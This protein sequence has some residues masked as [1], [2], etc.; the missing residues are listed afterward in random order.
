MPESIKQSMKWK[1]ANSPV[2][3]KFQ[4]QQSV[5]K[6]ML[7]LFRN[8]EGPII[9]DF[10]EKVITVTSASHCQLLSPIHLIY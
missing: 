3:K 9:I 6:V 8:M 7:A 4:A 5:K 2:K 10:L 1:H